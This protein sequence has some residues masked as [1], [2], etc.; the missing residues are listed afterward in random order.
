MGRTGF[1]K[2]HRHPKKLRQAGALQIPLSNFPTFH[3]PPAHCQLP[4]ANFLPPIPQL[5]PTLTFPNSITRWLTRESA[6]NRFIAEIDGLR[7]LAIAGVLLYHLGHFFSV[8]SGF[9]TSA[10]A[11]TTILHQGG[12]GVHLFF[13]ISGFVIALPFAR[14]YLMAT[15]KPRLKRF[16]F[17]RFTRLEPPYFLNLIILFALLVIVK[18]Q[19]PVELLPHLAASLFYIHGFVFGEPSLINHV[20]WSLEI[21]F[22]FYLLAPFFCIVFAIGQTWWRRFVLA[23]IVIGVST[24]TV[25]AAPEAAL[26]RLSLVPFLPFFFCGFLL[27]DLWVLGGDKMR[28]HSGFAWDVVG[29]SA[30]VAA[31]LVVSRYAWWPA[32]LPPLFLLLSYAAFRG[33]ALNALLCWRPVYMIGGHCYTIYLY[34]FLIISLIGNPLVRAFESTSLGPNSQILI[35]ALVIMPSTV[36]VSGILFLL[37]ERPFM[38]RDWPARI[39]AYLRRGAAK[40]SRPERTHA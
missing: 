8:K 18:G 19:S 25:T 36:I 30:L 32:V 40:D 7:F 1:L 34:H 35:G 12:I 39:Y 28:E 10:T 21:E 24:W 2:G 17:R 22:Q 31:P 23:A 16:Y 37:T 20:A 27:A 11:F 38:V 3:L 13:V 4:T 26:H 14:H 15:Q 33:R 6:S 9:S 5:P 29:T